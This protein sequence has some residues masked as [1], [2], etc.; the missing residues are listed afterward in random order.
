[1]KEAHDAQDFRRWLRISESDDEK[2]RRIRCL[3]NMLRY[4]Q[5]VGPKEA[6]DKIFVL[7]PEE[8]IDLFR[9]SIEKYINIRSSSQKSTSNGNEMHPYLNTMRECG[10]LDLDVTD[11]LLR[12][13]V[14][15]LWKV[16]NPI[17]RQ[18]LLPMCSILI[19]WDYSTSRKRDR[20]SALTF[21]GQTYNPLEFHDSDNLPILDELPHL[22]PTRARQL[23][24]N[25]V[26]FAL[27]S[28]GQFQWNEIHDDYKLP[29]SILKLW[30]HKKS[31]RTK[32]LEVTLM[33][34]IVSFL[35]YMLLDTYGETGG[36]HD[37]IISERIPKKP[38]RQH[39]YK[40]LRSYISL[41]K[42]TDLRKVVK[43]YA[44]FVLS[45]ETIEKEIEE[46]QQF[47]KEILCLLNLSTNFMI[48]LK[49]K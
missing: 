6:F 45:D 20:S 13:H 38:Y 39:S 36:Q 29:L 26:D 32:S 24:L 28:E 30:L 2:C 27:E 3:Y 11:I 9:K 4:I 10:K 34:L 42:R 37:E 48:F 33:A 23:V 46:C 41:E 7:V 16:T 49:A 1:M 40:D 18:L 31:D 5:K 43:N 35:K 8:H 12:R 44:K 19:K 15:Y 25:C 17:H 47:Y 22:D 14:L 21:N